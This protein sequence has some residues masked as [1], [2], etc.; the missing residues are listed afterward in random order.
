MK[1]TRELFGALVLLVLFALSAVAQVA[2]ADLQVGVKDV[3]G[4]V[5]KNATVVVRNTATGLERTQTAN[6]DGEYQFR[7]LPPGH[8]EVTITASGFAK[9]KANDVVITVGQVAELPVNL[10][11]ATVKEEVTVSTEAELVETQQSSSS[12]TI[13][14]TRI[15]NLP[16]NGRN[17]INFALTNSQLARDTTPSIG[18]AP[19][20]GI[21]AGG[22]RAR[23]NQV[24]VDGMDAVDNSTNGIRSTVSQ[25]AVQEFQ[26]QTEG[27]TA[28]YGRA[29]GAVINIVTKTGTN[30][31]H[32]SAYGYLR[33]RNIQATN[34]FSTVNKPAYTRTQAGFALGGPIK[35]DRTYYFFSFETTRRNESGY[36]SIGQDNFGLT[37][38]ADIT[39]Y[40]N[41]Y[42]ASNGIP[43]V[44]P[45]GTIVVPV[46]PQQAGFLNA[47]PITA[48]TIGYAFLVGGSSTVALSGKNAVTPYLGVPVG[49]FG[50]FVPDPN[51][52]TAPPAPIPLPSS[53]VPLSTVGGN[54]P[55]GEITDIAS[56]RLDHRLTNN[57]T[58]SV[59]GGISPSQISGIQVNAQG[60]Q[61]FGQNAFS[62]TSRQDYHDSSIN[63][64]HSWT[65]GTNKVNEFRFQYSRRGLLYS[66]AD[67]PDGGK[68]GVN[69][70]GVA[71]FGREPFSFVNR[72]EQRYE[73]T[74]H[75]S[76]TKGKH[77]MKWGADVNYLPLE[78]DFTVNFGGV[79]DFGDL[80][81]G[82]GAPTLLAVQAYGA[83]M[84]QTFIQGV[85]NPH[86]KF[87]NT[88]LAGFWQDS[89]RMTHNLTLN[90][91]VRYDVEFTPTFAATTPEAAAAQ[92]A[93]GITQG[94]PRDNN[95]IAPRIGIAWDPKGDGKT[96][97]RSSFGIFYDH[98]LLALAFD[99]D[100]ADGS[101]APQIGLGFGLP[102]RDC[103][104]SA[105]NIFTGVLA[106][107]CN[108]L[109]QELNYQADQQRFNPTPNAPTAWANQAFL[110]G[111]P[112]G[113]PIP[114]TLLPF[115]LPTAK[116]FVYPYSN[117]AT[118]GI[119]HDLGHDMALSLN[120]NFVGGRHLNRPINVNPVRTDLLVQNWRN[121]LADG[122]PG[123]Q[124][125]PL[126]VG[127][128]GGAPCGATWIAPAIV[129]FFR[130][131]GLNP[132]YLGQY[133]YGIGGTPCEAVANGL[134]SA[135]GLGAGVPVPFSDMLG[136]FSN[137]SS[138]Y[139]GFTANL[140]KRF[141]KHYEFLASYTWSHAIDDSTDLQTPLA[142]QDNFNPSAE[143]STSA[144]DQRHRFVFSGVVQSGHRG[145]GF[146]GALMNDWTV[147]PI[148]EVG[149][150]RPFNII[151]GVDNNFDFG[152]LTDRPSIAQ[153]NETN[154]CGFTAA[155]SKYS[156]TGYL[157]APCWQDGVFT[158]NL[159][160]NSGIRPATV[161]T[162]MRV[163]KRISLT[164]RV[165]LDAIMD[166]FNLINRFNVA[167][168]NPLWDQAGKAT[169]AFDPRQFQFALRLSW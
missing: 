8:Y 76:L 129:S 127:S 83:G 29:S 37:S 52:P 119:E 151:T 1:T 146:A 73:F 3:K 69:I 168:V 36:T 23:G 82:G 118:F 125:S 46:T 71:F 45:A 133:P 160:R 55:V 49:S 78:A 94:I 136:N 99:S 79:Y 57:Q 6:V 163:S 124:L 89:W 70:P 154:S 53:Y 150:G 93:L 86:D 87:S 65:I 68:V 47:A 11:L 122:D 132:S 12:T 42:Y 103:T 135:Y 25:E 75:F 84:P 17:Y 61:N 60:P 7:A 100:V 134:I 165:K 72:T 153:A 50:Y 44:L 145:G 167:D 18:A 161:F 4:A 16:I 22:Q 39:K 120:Y 92:N 144:F 58:L 54:F 159:P 40:M 59:R 164:E 143:R 130:P 104:L 155:P 85:G 111:G 102:S 123:A 141:S 91:G 162:D 41:A 14:Q 128:E 13:E 21:N 43:V 74:D 95:N 80:N 38:T 147:A 156:P 137:G 20:S 81:L 27:Y 115:G 48:G 33:N 97:I 64:Q 15:D 110:T 30:E 149:S 109:A 139:H 169:A 10:E 26:L 31:F 166:G 117:Q 9:G 96:V 77:N 157:I 2:T 126:L 28:E 148:I 107:Y 24:N 66:Y 56:L 108:P 63:A 121:A 152:T 106:T 35:K 142:P 32:G 34:P 131:S 88:A 90:Y 105:G 112:N 19:T 116:N 114:L 51:N 158:G 101:Q 62:R 138:V 67:T 140:K 98:P 5:V 113:N